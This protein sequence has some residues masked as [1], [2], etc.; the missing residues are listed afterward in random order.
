MLK[1]IMDVLTLNPESLVRIWIRKI[2][3]AA[4]LKKYNSLPDEELQAM[5]VKLYK[6]LALWFEKEIDKNKIGSFFV[7]I[8]K[9][10]R[11]EGFAV[12]EVTYALLLAQRSVLEYISNESTLDSS[13]ALYNVLDLTN[14]V[15]DFF[16]LGSYYM[17][18]GY[19]EDTYVA[20]SQDEAISEEVLKKYFS[21]EFFFKDSGKIM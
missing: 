20:L 17:M 5:N 14:Q 4:N 3:K 1:K 13:M 19:L 2:R 18:K 7:D 15:A 21:D 16:F 10:R 9:L 6:M 11:S 8:G 12:S